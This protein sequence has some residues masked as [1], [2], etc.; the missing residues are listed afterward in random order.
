MNYLLVNEGCTLGFKAPVTGSITILPASIVTKIG[1]S[2]KKVYNS[3]S[4]AI[5]GATDGTVTGGTLPLVV[6]QGNS[7][8]V[9]GNLLPVVREDAEVTVVVPGVVGTSPDT[10]SATVIVIDAGQTKL[11]GI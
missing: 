8:K 6:L 3:I 11:K 5:S 2:G 1:A 4:F 10:F 9:K 7:E